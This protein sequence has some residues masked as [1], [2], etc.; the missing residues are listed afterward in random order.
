MQVGSPVRS[1]GCPSLVSQGPGLNGAANSH[2]GERLRGEE[3]L[4]GFVDHLSVRE[5]AGGD[6]TL[7]SRSKD[8]DL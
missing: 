5:E 3:R 1:T 8:S 4:I 7:R 6:V 2:A